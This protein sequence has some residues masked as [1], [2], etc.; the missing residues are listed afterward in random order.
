MLVNYFEGCAP[1]MHERPDVSLTRAR[2]H[3][4]GPAHARHAW[5]DELEVDGAYRPP[6]R[7]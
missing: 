2:R 5:A 1:G 4:V 7:G 3:I 6:R